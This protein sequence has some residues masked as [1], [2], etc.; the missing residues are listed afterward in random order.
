MLAMSRLR[1]DYHGSGRSP[2]RANFR[3]VDDT[4]GHGLMHGVLQ[5]SLQLIIDR[6]YNRRDSRLWLVWWP[7]F[8]GS[9]PLRTVT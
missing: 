7:G 3:V 6:Y 5:M 9:T 4:S 1:G 8:K 2:L